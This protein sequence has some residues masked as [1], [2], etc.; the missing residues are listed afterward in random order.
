MNHTLGIIPQYNATT[1]TNKTADKPRQS[2]NT[3]YIEVKILWVK[4]HFVKLQFQSICG[5]IYTFLSGASLDLLD[6][7]SI[8]FSDLRNQGDCFQIS[9]IKGIWRIL[10]IFY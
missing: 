9:G 2:K 10:K 7:S 4:P 3:N 8:L 1:K 5:T 6:V